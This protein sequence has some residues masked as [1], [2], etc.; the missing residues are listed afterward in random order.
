M[1]NENLI[2][3]VQVAKTRLNGV[4][5]IVSGNVVSVKPGK[6]KAEGRAVTVSIVG[7]VYNKETG[8][9]EKKYI[10]ATFFNSQKDED[11]LEG[12]HQWT[13]IISKMN[14]QP[15][16][17]VM[18]SVFEKGEDSSDA[19]VYGNRIVRGSGII[20]I[21]AN[22]EED[23]GY[24]VICGS[25]VAV[26]HNAENGVCNVT[27]PTNDLVPGNGFQTVNH[28]VAFWNTEKNPD[29]AAKMA[30]LLT[31]KQ[32]EDGSTSYA[33]VMIVTGER[34]G[35]IVSF[36]RKNGETGYSA[37]YVGFG[38]N[39]VP[40]RKKKTSPAASDSTT[41]PA[42]A[43]PVPED[44]EVPDAMSWQEIPDELPWQ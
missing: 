44:E 15:G 42:N 22:G 5:K 9:T 12:K 3:L 25:V 1:A 21:R 34:K 20:N 31:P 33:R 17:P 41:T 13:E 18:M 19:R 35:D 4:E 11:V 27:I 24:N 38:F 2:R 40:K 43:A 7:G 10:N 30:D 16:E 36:E 26:R 28:H 29:N 14:L 37:D 32:E 8:E 39:F 23:S 6:G